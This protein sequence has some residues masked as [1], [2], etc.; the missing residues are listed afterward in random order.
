MTKQQQ[1]VAAGDDHAPKD[2]QAEQQVQSDG[3]AENFGQVAGGDGDF[4]QG[5]QHVVDALRVVVVAGLGQVAAGHQA[6]PCAQGLQQHGHG[7]AHQQHPDEPVAEL[8]A[9]LDVGGPI[10]GIH[11][12]DRN[13]IG[14]TGKGK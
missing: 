5:E 10:A 13:Q 4:A 14:R 12:A 11:V 9:A 7:V 3:R 2:G 8:R 6:E 1:H